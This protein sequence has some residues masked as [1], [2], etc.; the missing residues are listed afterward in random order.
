VLVAATG[1]AGTGKTT[2]LEFLAA[3]G[4]GTY[5]Y[6]GGIVR[7]EIV[8]RGLPASPES[9]REVREALRAAEGMAA[10]ARRAGPC[11]RDH[12][13]AG[14]TVL[15]DA[16]C[17]LEEADFYRATFGAD[18]KILAI[19]TTFDIRAKRLARRCPRPLSRD[20]LLARDRYELDKLA[21]GE[22]VAGAD[23]HVPNSAGRAPFEAALRSFAASLQ[24]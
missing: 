10:L 16:V 14:E 3:I 8:A 5:F 17:N 15:V 13:D 23:V 12:L 19:E 21:I 9:E 7:D 22:V 2:G 18:V 4:A 1:L 6:V 11:L 24:A 20:Q